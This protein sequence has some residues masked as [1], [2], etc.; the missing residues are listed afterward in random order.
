MFI[1]H[2]SRTVLVSKKFMK[3]AGAL[4]SN[5][6]REIMELRKSFPDYSIEIKQVTKAAPKS[7]SGLSYAFMESYIQMQDNH[8]ELMNEFLSLRAL[9]MNYSQIKSWFLNRISEFPFEAA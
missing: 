7:H 6:C 5:E 1:D 2:V 4:G 9:G 8:D 3:A